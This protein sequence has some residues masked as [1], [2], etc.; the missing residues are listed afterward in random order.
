MVSSSVPEQQY[1][2][3]EHLPL[4]VCQQDTNSTV[5]RCSPCHGVQHD[6]SC[7]ETLSTLAG[8]PFDVFVTIA[9]CISTT[10]QSSPETL[11]ANE[12]LDIQHLT[13]RIPAPTAHTVSWIWDA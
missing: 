4:A 3:H 8:M 12:Q 10:L 5:G 6:T 2:I 11:L 13:V 1:T 9:C 7:W